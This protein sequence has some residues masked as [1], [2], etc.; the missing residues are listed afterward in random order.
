M[1]DYS[2]HNLNKLAM[3]SC[4]SYDSKHSLKRRMKTL[5]MNSLILRRLFL[6]KL[7]TLVVRYAK[8]IFEVLKNPNTPQT[9][10]CGFLT[11]LAKPL[12]NINHK[13]KI[14]LFPRITPIEHIIFLRINIWKHSL[15][16][17]FSY[18]FSVVKS[19]IK[20]Q[21]VSINFFYQ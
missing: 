12:N 19:C 17:N 5:A 20:S 13:L 7:V 4:L 11:I 21:A 2:C 18:Q 10:V 6:H 15:P 14:H 3:R 8:I 16:N 9:L 1:Q